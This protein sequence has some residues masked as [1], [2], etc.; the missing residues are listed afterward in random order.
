MNRSCKT[1]PLCRLLRY[2][3]R[4]PQE[5]FVFR[6][7]SK[8]RKDLDIVGLLNDNRAGNKLDSR[9]PNND[10]YTSMVDNIEA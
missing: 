3:K 2:L 5:K 10:Y 1:L 8:Q 6:S 7:F 9:D 4:A